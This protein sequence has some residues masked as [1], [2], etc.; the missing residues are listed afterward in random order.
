[1]GKKDTTSSVASSCACSPACEGPISFMHLPSDDPELVAKGEGGRDICPKT[2]V[3]DV[4]PT[5]PERWAQGSMLAARCGVCG[6]LQIVSPGRQGCLGCK[7]HP[8]QLNAAS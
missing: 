1:M 2:F 8:A 3:R 6:L 5:Q 7:A 4:M